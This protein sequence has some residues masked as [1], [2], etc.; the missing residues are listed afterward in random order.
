MTSHL[1]KLEPSG[2][3]RC[4]R[5]SAQSQSHSQWSSEAQDHRSP[6]SLAPGS[7]EECRITGQQVSALKGVVALAGTVSQAAHGLPVMLTT[8]QAEEV[9]DWVSLT[10]CQQ[11][12]PSAQREGVQ[13]DSHAAGQWDPHSWS[14][15]RGVL[16]AQVP[17]V[18]GFGESGKE[19]THGKRE[20]RKGSQTGGQV[21]ARS[22]FVSIRQCHGPA[23]GSWEAARAEA[24]EMG[25]TR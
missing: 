15:D 20:G 21:R 6:P 3:G 8:A 19:V 4:Q 1:G 5:A 12:Q 7:P 9:T 2:A 24:G 17:G 14:G 22:A 23:P 11:P 25:G 10:Q 18:R 13:C 16:P